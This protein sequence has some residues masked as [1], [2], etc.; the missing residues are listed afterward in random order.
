[1]HARTRTPL[2]AAVIRHARGGAAARGADIEYFITLGYGYAGSSPTSSL[3]FTHAGLSSPV[4][5]QYMS[6]SFGRFHVA[7]M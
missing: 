1:M 5:L 6:N 2:G 7:I 3:R 4:N